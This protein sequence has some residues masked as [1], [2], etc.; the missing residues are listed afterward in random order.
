MKKI[1]CIAAAVAL[2]VGAPAKAD[3]TKELLGTML[4]GAVGGYAGSHIGK[5]SGRLA[6]TAGGAVLGAIV[7]NGAGSSL[8]RADRMYQGGYGGGYY[9]PPPVAYRRPP[10]AYAPAPVYVERHTYQYVPV[11]VYRERKVRRWRDYD[12][13]YGYGGV[14]YAQ[15]RQHCREYQSSVSVGGWQQPGYGTACLQPDGS[16]QIVR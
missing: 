5:G 6:A 14:G 4:G 13:D 15:P 3:G 8:D 9:A 1:A 10:P 11:P 16:W 2:L 12:D 7:G